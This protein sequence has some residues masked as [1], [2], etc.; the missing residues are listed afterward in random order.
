MK[1][2]LP[3]Q[4]DDLK[5]LIDSRFGRAQGYLIVDTS[6]E[7]GEENFIKNPAAGAAQGAGVAAAQN[8]VEKGVQAVIVNFI[9]PNAYRALDSAN[10]KVYQVK[11][12][13]SAESLIKQLKSDDLKKLS[14][15][16]GPPKKGGGRQRRGQQ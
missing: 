8:L 2:A 3:A 5:A 11:S 10:V 15:P 13:Q 14:K 6:K 7:E 4:N 12:K 1:I 9:G 16:T